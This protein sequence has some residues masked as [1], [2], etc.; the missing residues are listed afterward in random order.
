MTWNVGSVVEEVHKYINNVPTAISGTNMN[1]TV[2]RS[3]S[4]IENYTGVDIGTTDIPIK[5]HSVIL[6]KSCLNIL[7]IKNTKSSGQDIKLGDFHSKSPGN[8][9]NVVQYDKYLQLYYR[10]LNSLGKKVRLFKTGG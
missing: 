5:Y 10:E 9:S 3:I 6:Y 8:S 4:D 2:E 1:S 7:G